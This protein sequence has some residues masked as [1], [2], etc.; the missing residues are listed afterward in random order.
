M[1]LEQ[2][3]SGF[4]EKINHY[5]LITNK[6]REVLPKLTE[7]LDNTW[8]GSISEH[9]TKRYFIDSFSDSGSA[10]RLPDKVALVHHDQ[11]LTYRDLDNLTS[12]LANYLVKNG[13]KPGDS[14]F[15]FGQVFHFINVV[16][17]SQRNLSMVW[18]MMGILKAGGAVSLMDPVYPPERIVNCLEVAQPRGWICVAG[19]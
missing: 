4:G 2:A 5:S 14:L 19:S 12:K 11:T 8:F 16:F 10:K 18:A 1:V 7:L 9:F 13:I 3:V 6:A 17:I 15:I